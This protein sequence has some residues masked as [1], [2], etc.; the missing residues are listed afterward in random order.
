M[1]KTLTNTLKKFLNEINAIRIAILDRR[2]PW[3]AR[4]L[5][6]VLIFYFFSPIDLIPDFIPVLGQLDDIIIIPVGIYIVLKM[7]PADVMSEA[8]EK[9]KMKSF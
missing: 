7:I 9:A 1:G 2:T 4:A 8:R 5:A 3:Y 6:A